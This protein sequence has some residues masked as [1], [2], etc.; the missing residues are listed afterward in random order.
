MA[1][2]VVEPRFAGLGLRV[3]SA[4]A[5]MPPVLGAVY[6]G[7]PYFE[8][9]LGGCAVIMAWEWDRLCGGRTRRI[10]VF[11]LAA[12]YV[13]TV[14]LTSLGR[15]AMAL[16][17]LLAGSA[18][19]LVLAARWRKSMA[20]DG[21]EGDPGWRVAGAFYI[22][23]CCIALTWLRTEPALGFETVAWLLATVW[24]VDIGA[25]ICGRLIG[26]P[27][28]V[29]AISPNKTV[30]GLL[31]G[32]ASAGAVGVAAAVVFDHQSIVP[33]ATASVAL[34]FVAQTGDVAESWVKRRHGIKDSSHIIPGHGGILDRVDGLLAA[35]AVTA[36]FFATREGE[37]FTWS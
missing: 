36:L 5:M 29:P 23:A 27:R 18:G 4:L 15:P 30:S 37:V 34:G 13:A 7:S 10:G 21:A 14:V 28:L 35:A 25:Y 19:L 17:F 8:I 11:A 3:V 20:L 2:P 9:L 1:H 33:L 16:A 6:F 12:T 24:A 31:G 26:G 22:G 32:M